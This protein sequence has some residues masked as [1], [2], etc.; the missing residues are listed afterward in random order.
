[1]LALIA[2]ILLAGYVPPH[3]D[4]PA[5]VPRTAAIFEHDGPTMGLEL[6]T[7]RCLAE[8]AAGLPLP[9]PCDGS[10]TLRCGADR[11]PHVR[12]DSP[13]PLPLQ[14]K[15]RFIPGTLHTLHDPYPPSPPP[16][17]ST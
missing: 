1:M 5:P 6:A 15:L 3:A 11:A 17:H 2:T 14:Q 9:C 8:V 16:R 12:A 4:T 10:L 7:S 13:G